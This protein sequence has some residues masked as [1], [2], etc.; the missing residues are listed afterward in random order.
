MHN[1]ERNQPWL[2]AVVQPARTLEPQVGE[3]KKD[4][5]GAAPLRNACQAN[6]RRQI[7]MLRIRNRAAKRLERVA[8]WVG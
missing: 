3:T 6:R 1:P 2:A 7:V 8:G 5:A 4:G